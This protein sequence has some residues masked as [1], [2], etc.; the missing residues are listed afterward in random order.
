MSY[1][2]SQFF[3]VEIM[4]PLKPTALFPHEGFKDEK[5][6]PKD[7]IP[8]TLFFLCMSSFKVLFK[9]HKFLSKIKISIISNLIEVYYLYYLISNVLGIRF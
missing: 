8:Q 5:Y 2:T 3:I 4:R 9:F 6:R 7:D 1:I